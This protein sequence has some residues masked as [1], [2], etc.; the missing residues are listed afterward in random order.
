MEKEQ[1]QT[2]R[3]MP[4]IGRARMLVAA[5]LG[6]LLLNPPVLE[7]FSADPSVRLFGS[8]LI[9]FYINMIWGLLILMVVLP[10]LGLVIKRL[11]RMIKPQPKEGAN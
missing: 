2:K 10:R 11:W 4:G 9:L 8:S 6:A 3:K 1:E 5:L 7:I